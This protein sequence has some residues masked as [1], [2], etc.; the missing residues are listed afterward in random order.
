MHNEDN[1]STKL[2]AVLW[3]LMN[4]AS[5]EFSTVSGLLALPKPCSTT[6]TT[7]GKYAL[8]TD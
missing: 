8:R 1:N 4:D 3:D 7:G 2:Q 6:A 5:K